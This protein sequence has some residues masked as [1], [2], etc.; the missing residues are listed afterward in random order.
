MHCENMI[1]EY[2]TIERCCNIKIK[3]YTSLFTTIII[4]ALGSFLTA[5]DFLAIFTR[6]TINRGAK[7]VEV[8]LLPH[9]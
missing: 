2:I 8:R 1:V 7:N 4:I 3:V 5:N 6:P 9:N